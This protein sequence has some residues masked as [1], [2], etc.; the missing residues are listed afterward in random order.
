M[1][2]IISGGGI[3]GLT[4]ALCLEKFG[5]EIVVLEQAA[6]FSEVGA[7]LQVSP[8]GM[9][10]LIAL[11]LAAP[12]KGL[13]F[14]PERIELRFGE[15]GQVI[16]DIPL[17]E[18]AETRWGAPYYHLHRADLLGVLFAAAM[19]T[20]AIT[21][22]NDARLLRYEQSNDCVQVTLQD[23]RELS[24]DMLIG[25][26]GLHSAV[27]EQML[28]PEEPVF[29][30]CI[31]W[32]GVIPMER[33]SKAPPPPTACAW[34]GRGKHAVTYRLRRG[35]LANFVGVVE[36]PEF[37]EESWSA[38]G[39]KEQIAEDFSGWHPVISEMIE[40]GEHFFRW[41]LFGR[42]PL[43][44]WSDGNVTLLG[45]ACHPML[46]FLAQGAVMAIEDAWVLAGCLDGAENISGALNRYETLRRPR[47]TKVQA[48]ARANANT[49]HHRS[50]AA[51]LATYGPMW[52]GSRIFPEAVHSRMDWIYGHDVTG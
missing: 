52:L 18:K 32:R 28:G 20:Q 51:R 43:A 48:G 42:E 14:A 34:V 47:T 12:L 10:V 31:A 46:P 40:Q 49:F 41:G 50:P 45:D 17:K 11:G 27:R 38:T 19:D 2:I 15:S 21:I 29:T 25:A 35:E 24:G 22:R 1:K 39:A 23:G 6:E 13:A 16:F 4:A 33:L 8:N 26:D 7:G 36:Q 9:K 3:G 37:T 30:K 44:K 5:H